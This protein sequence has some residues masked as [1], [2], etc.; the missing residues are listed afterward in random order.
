VAARRAKT[1]AN[2]TLY[3]FLSVLV[4]IIGA[5]M[6]IIQSMMMGQVTVSAEA[7]PPPPPKLDEVS[8]E[9]RAAEAEALADEAGTSRKAADELERQIAEVLTLRQAI[10]EARAAL[11]EL[12]KSLKATG[13]AE[14]AAVAKLQEHT[15]LKNRVLELEAELKRLLEW[16]ADIKSRFPAPVARDSVI[17]QPSGTGRNMNPLFIECTAEALVMHPGGERIRKADIGSSTEFRNALAKIRP[18]ST[19]PVVKTEPVE[20]PV[21][22]WVGRLKDR[23]TENRRAAAA[24][25]G[26]MGPDAK[27]ALPELREALKDE[28]PFVRKAAEAAITAVTGPPLPKVPKVEPKPALRPPDIV[29]FLIR[30]DGVKVFDEAARVARERNARFGHLPVPVQGPLDLSRFR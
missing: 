14:K 6:L 20:K 27:E 10:A 21:S 28:N 11:A 9:T 5:L 18:G 17:V 23:L 2:M 7:P 24:A 15:R 1:L 26:K 13:A 4:C 19:A 25:L 29:I 8:P 3:P 30:P 16:I 22:Y 12:E